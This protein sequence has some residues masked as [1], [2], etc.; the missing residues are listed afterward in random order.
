MGASETQKEE[1]T[2]KNINNEE[3]EV[4]ESEM[5]FEE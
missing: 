5:E 2:K 3:K 1:E 4:R